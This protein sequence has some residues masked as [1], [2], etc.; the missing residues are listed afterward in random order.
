MLSQD[1]LQY[2]IRFP[3]VL[4]LDTLAPPFAQY[5]SHLLD[6]AALQHN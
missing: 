5:R 1:S 6:G 2:L 3:G 4:E